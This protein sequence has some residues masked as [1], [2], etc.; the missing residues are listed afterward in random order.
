MVLE[1]TEDAKLVEDDEWDELYK[2]VYWSKIKLRKFKVALHDLKSTGPVDASMS[3]PL[4]IRDNDELDM[5]ASP[6]KK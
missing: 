2:D 3:K 5:I 6:S 4:S 1:V